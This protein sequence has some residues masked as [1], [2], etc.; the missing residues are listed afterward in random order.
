[1]SHPIEALL[2]PPVE[3]WSALTAG[4]AAAICVGA[5]QKFLMSPNL[6]YVTGGLLGAFALYRLRQGLR[7]V[8][9][10]R[11]LRRLKTYALRADQIPV[12][13]KKL[14]LG[15]GFK[16]SQIHTQRLRDTERPW[17]KP[18]VEPGRL[19]RFARWTET[20]WE[21][22]P[23]G[24]RIAAFL[25]MDSA[26]NPVRPLPPVGGK[27]A[28]HGVEPN[29][30]PVWMPL[31]DRVGH[32]LVLG[33]TRVGKTR[34][35]EILITQD[36]ARGDVVIV[37]DP[38]GDADLMRR[39]VAEAQRAGRENALY[40]F[41][42]GFP[43]F[44]ARYNPIGSF[45]RITEVAT[46]ISN[47]LPNEGNAAAFR[48]FAWLF[49]NIVARALYALGQ[50]PTY[51]LVV[52]YVT[53]MDD[54]F[55]EY[56][57]FW[58]GRVAPGWEVEVSAAMGRINERDLPRAMQ[59]RD[60][61]VVALMQYIQAKNLYDRT[62][63]GL[64]W[65]AR[66]DRTYFDKLTV[67]L[68]PMM[69]KLMTGK[70][71][72][73][74]SPNY[75]DSGDARPI[76]DWLGVIKR[77]GIVYVGLDAMSDFA[78]SAAVGNSMFADLVSVAGHIYKHGAD[79]GLPA[80]AKIPDRPPISIHA[81]EFNELIGNEFV[82]LLNKAGGAGVQVTA[83]TQTLSDIEARIGDKAKAGQI[84]GNCNNLVMLRVREPATAELLTEQLPEV[85]IQTLTL[86]SGV[87]DAADPTETIDFQSR[88]EDRVNVE[89]AP[90]LMPSDL[91]ALP[92]GQAFCLLEGGQLWKVR[93]PLPD[94]GAD[95]AM[96]A[97]V[98]EL[99]AR[100]RNHYA[101]ADHWWVGAGAGHG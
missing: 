55:T 60:K 1:M 6:G 73:L 33:T 78:V 89:A 50:R 66:L 84:I 9:Y 91:I 77:K 12:S 82:P 40:V 52:R 67:S 57:R 11:N 90:M 41:H 37:F 75:D 85:Q 21:H 14:F 63:D 19:Y 27:P 20:A 15:M 25:A 83:Y 69:E 62:A 49:T 26:W 7:V 46:R 31:A 29:E 79:G 54:L 70:I 99:A 76:F 95:P 51:E 88:N 36:I 101:T 8:G 2:R 93:F 42:L 45:S 65:A 43:E 47:Q 64:L 53:H 72:E 48:E 17:A 44:S 13:R 30:G 81:D 5:P 87:T 10:Q 28:L 94:T 100:M 86:V 56:C 97:S 92:K 39:V 35:A 4:C 32:T 74:I 24:S 22:H 38:K 16:W 34:L 61:F 96:P 71:G 68:V 98:G 3:L 58:L 80:D 59:G 18:Y 23:V